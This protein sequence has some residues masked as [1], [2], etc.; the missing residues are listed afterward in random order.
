[1]KHTEYRFADYDYGS[2]D[3]SEEEE[4]VYLFEERDHVASLSTSKDAHLGQSVLATADMN[5]SNRRKG[6]VNSLAHID[7]FSPEL[8][9][10]VSSFGRMVES[11]R[12]SV[13]RYSFSKSSRGLDP[14]E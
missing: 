7:T 10:V 12:S 14:N 11:K 2:S 1:M 13:K 4:A 9:I 3:E 5:K 6:D 8:G